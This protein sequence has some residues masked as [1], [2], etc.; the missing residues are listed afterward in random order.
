MIERLIR[1][2]RSGRHH[3]LRFLAAAAVL[4]PLAGCSVF[5]APNANNTVVITG[6]YFV[7]CASSASPQPG[8]NDCP[9]TIYLYV[10]KTVTTGY[11]SVS[12][13][14][15][16]SG[17]CFHGEKQVLAGAGAGDIVVGLKN[18]Y[19]SKCVAS[20]PTTVNVYDGHDGDASAR[21]L[22]SLKFTVLRSC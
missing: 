8:W 20:Y 9:A 6:L 3:M 19:V 4:A 11:V 13:Q 18:P 2:P 1:R 15:P 14:Y 22:A 5:S 7:A 16:E 21:Q 17:S 12:F 10:S